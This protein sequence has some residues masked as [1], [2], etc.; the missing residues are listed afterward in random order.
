M[1]RLVFY[2]RSAIDALTQ[3]R[4]GETKLGQQFRTIDSLEA[5]GQCPAHFVI[6]GIPEDIGVRANHG[7][8]GTA[9]FWEAT[10]KALANVQSNVFL[11]GREMLLLGYFDIAPFEDSDFAALSQRVSEIDDMVYPVIEQIVRA[12]K[13]PII[14]GGGHN[15]AYPILKGLSRAKEKPMDAVNIDAHADLRATDGRHSG[16][17]FSYAIQDG[18]LSGYGIF[19]L[20]ENYNNATVLSQIEKSD[21]ISC[22]YFDELIKTKDRTSIWSDFIKPFDYQMGLEIDMDAIA[23]SLSS[24]STPTGFTLNDVRKML[25]CAK[26]K[27]AYLH[28]AEGAV[29]LSDGRKDPSGAKAAAYLVTDFVKAQLNW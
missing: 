3:V 20:H 26:K 8:A 1:D 27:V 19:G 29:E 6:L 4:D 5:L 9:G 24:A 11:G 7:M 12:G 2:N 22:L 21:R 25:L 16:N 10:V 18:Y 23:N 14:V 17:A 15:N 13:V 28:I